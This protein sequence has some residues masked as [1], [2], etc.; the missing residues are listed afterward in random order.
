[1]IQ[2]LYQLSQRLDFEKV[3]SIVID[4]SDNPD[5]GGLLYHPTDGTLYGKNWVLVPQAGDYSQI[6]AYVQKY[7]FGNK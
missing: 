2:S 7:L 1:V 4:N 5:E 6:H 3:T